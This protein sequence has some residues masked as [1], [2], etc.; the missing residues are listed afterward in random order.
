MPR[1]PLTDSTPKGRLLR[2]L[3]LLGATTLLGSATTLAFAAK[4]PVAHHTPP[5]P[6]CVPS[7]LNRSDV[8][9]GTSLQVAPLPDSLDAPN[10]TQISFLGAPASALSGISVRGSSSGA[11]RGRLAAYSQGDGASFVPSGPF[12]SGESVTVHGKV[13]R[14]GRTAPFAFHFTTAVRDQIA[15]PPSSVKPTGRSGELFT[16]HSRP[17]LH[18]PLVTITGSSPPQAPGYVFAA[19][20]SGPGQDGPMIF[21]DAGNLIWFDPLPANTEAADLQVQ[22]YEGR[23]VLTWWQGYI[24]PQG[25]GLGEEVI[26]DSSYRQILRMRAGNGLLAD[27]HDFHITAQNTALLTA[28]DPI[29]CNLSSVGGPSD[30]AV[31]DSLFQEID[32]KTHLVRREWH[33]LD[34]VGLSQSYS[35][36]ASTSTAWPFDYFHLNSVYIRRA[37][38]IL[39]SARD[40]SALY[41]L[42]ASTGQVLAQIGGKQGSEKLGAGATTAYQHDAEELP[43]GDITIFDN[44][45]VPMVHAQSRAI[46]VTLD[47]TTKTETL[48]TQYEHPK[49]LRAGSQGNVQT[50]ENGDVFI[51]WG[52]VPYFS[53]YTAAGALVFDA[54]LPAKTESYRGY[55]FQWTGAPTGSPSVAAGAGPAGTTTVYA[56]WNGA[57]SVAGWRVLAGAATNQLAPVASAAASGFETA[58]AAPG[59]PAYVA[60]QALD[61]AGNVLGT[62][63]AIR[64]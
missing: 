37:G 64:G 22:Q 26:A 25:F 63:P 19:P 16:L 14:A 35:K 9:P 46:V 39:I 4:K 41:E 7:Q 21:D 12:R 8:L 15:H 60:V 13:S 43:N 52:A 2:A 49:R 40:T 42:N 48:V 23:P 6:Q 44:G 53:E 3:A 1:D 36:P 51:G 18:A 47:P 29:H 17:D 58:V 54:H 34:H 59:A 57:T 32:M 30:G 31:T 62:S 24:P 27:L 33:P 11:H 28:F 20:Y 10:T 50:L 45:G 5:A 38:S 56:S 61:G 55:R